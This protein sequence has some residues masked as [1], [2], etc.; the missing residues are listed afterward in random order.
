MMT[1]MSLQRIKIWENILSF[2]ARAVLKKRQPFVVG[3]IGTGNNNLTKEATAL[4]LSQA[5]RVRQTPT[6]KNDELGVLLTIIGAPNVRVL[7]VSFVW[8][9]CKWLVIMV[10]PVRYPDILVL[11]INGDQDDM[12]HLMSFIPVKVAVVTQISASLK[13]NIKLI[14]LL[15]EDGFAILNADDALSLKIA[16]KTP[17]KVITYGFD[18][19]ALLA[20]DNILFHRSGERIEGFSFKLNYD[21]KTIPVRLPKLTE[22]YQIKAALAAAAVGIAFKMNLV[23]IASNLE[24]LD[25]TGLARL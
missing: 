4:V 18:K 21:G 14:A 9:F 17:A 24:E 6:D 1:L 19:N 20:V 25:V 7:F 15:P 12:E 2:M 10:L 11:E 8:V 22:P 23:E 3:I 13:D 16:E 5:Y